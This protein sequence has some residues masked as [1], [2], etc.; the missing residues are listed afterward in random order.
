MLS[1]Q[2]K[3]F[4][5]FLENISPGLLLKLR[6]LM[7]TGYEP[8]LEFIPLLCEK[9]KISIDVGAAWG[10]YAYYMKKLSKECWVFEPIPRNA[11][12]SH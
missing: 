7:K 2:K 3:L 4:I 12:L 5:K 8:E 9:D 6:I 10:K 1:K 11:K